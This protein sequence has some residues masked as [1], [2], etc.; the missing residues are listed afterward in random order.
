MNKHC[1][2]D[3][4]W[5]CWICNWRMIGMNKYNGSVRSLRMRIIW[6]V[7]VFCYSYYSR[8]K[9][10]HPFI[11]VL[12]FSQYWINGI[13]EFKLRSDELECCPAGWCCLLRYP[14]LPGKLRSIRKRVHVGMGKTTMRRYEIVPTRR[15]LR[16]EIQKQSISPFL[17]SIVPGVTLVA[18]ASWKPPDYFFCVYQVSSANPPP[19]SSSQCCPAGKRVHAHT[20]HFCNQLAGSKVMV[21]CC[22][23]CDFAACGSVQFPSYMRRLPADDFNFCALY[24]AAIMTTWIWK[25]IQHL[26]PVH[27]HNGCG[28][29]LSI[30]LPHAGGAP[31][32]RRILV[33]L[34][35]ESSSLV[36]QTLDSKFCFAAFSCHFCQE[37]RIKCPCSTSCCGL[38]G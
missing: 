8:F 1:L 24:A 10:V 18:L 35:I 19:K 31:L 13:S 25:K 23:T 20:W 34:W 28:G 16:R 3:F 9:V 29:N 17:V 4:P 36:S 2:T 32:H 5:N 33:F 15:R 27:F 7:I 30:L 12:Q 11:D 22:I 38:V 26:V 6:L 21:L 37:P 14:A